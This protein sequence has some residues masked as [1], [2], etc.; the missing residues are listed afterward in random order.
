MTRSTSKI[1]LILTAFLGI[2]ITFLTS[3]ASGTYYKAGA[4]Y[5][6]HPERYTKDSHQTYNDPFFRYS[7]AQPIQVD[8]NTTK[9]NKKKR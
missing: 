4:D 6:D 2:A 5:K 9:R 7:Q 3:C 1:I 8:C